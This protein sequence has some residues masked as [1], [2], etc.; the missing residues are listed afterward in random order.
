M[1]PIYLDYNATTPVDPRVA[2]AILPYLVGGLASGF[3]NPSSSHAYGRRA[4][5]AVEEARS[6]VARILSCDAAEIVFTGAGSEADNLAIVGVAEVYRE[7]G[8]HLITSQIEHPAVLN[9]CR[10]LEHR[11]YRVTYL[12]VDGECRVQ[13][14]DVARA[15]T[16]ETILITVMHS[17]NETG[18]LQP[19]AEI[20]TLARSRGILVHTDAAQSVGKLP[21]R[22]D[23]LG[24]DL[25]TMVGHKLYAPKGIGALYV[26]S[27]VR[28]EPLIHGAGHESGRRAGTENVP[29][30]VGLGK[31]CEIALSSLLKEGERLGALRD[32]LT[33]KLASS[34]PGLAR[35]G[36]PSEHLP[37]TVNVSFPGVDGEE[38]LAATPSVAA[39]T[40]SACHAGRTEPSAVLMAMGLSRER[41]LGAVRLSVGRFTT[42]AEVDQ[43]AEALVASW[44]SLV[45]R[46]S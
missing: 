18:T 37:N 32:R 4:Y 13:V 7:R 16:P 28:L 1:E 33:R 10:Y 8:N 44:R 14:A 22:V 5:L 12:P 9:T 3:G 41:A 15:I 17:N 36:H 29:S 24:V 42:E 30:I 39:S 35:N 26:R 11:G 6:Q 23:D 2:E 45:E 21:T 46:R 31:A 40:G 27:G 19:I 34:V 38:L 25:L 43:A 20:S